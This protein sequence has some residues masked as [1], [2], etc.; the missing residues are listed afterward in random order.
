MTPTQELLMEVLAARYRCGETLWTFD[1][2]HRKQLEKLESI[3]MVS[4]MDGMV[5]NT[6]RASLTEK[7][8]AEWISDRYVS[9]FQ[10]QINDAEERAK[11]WESEY[12]RATEVD[13]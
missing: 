5:E 7:G 2:R 3:G 6:C 13:R 4:V 8:K 9:P 11:F 10:K 1:A 12:R